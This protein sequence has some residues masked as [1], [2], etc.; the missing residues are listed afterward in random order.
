MIGCE[1]MSDRLFEHPA[2]QSA[3]A[4]VPPAKHCK[5]F[6]EVPGRD[7]LCFETRCTEDFVAEDA[8]V[9]AIDE[10]MERLDYSV[11]EQRYPGGGRPAWR[12]QLLAR[13]LLF[14][15][16]EGIRSAREISRLL[17]RDLHLM[18]LAHEQHI[19]HQRLSEFR[20]LFEAELAELFKQT[21]RLALEMGLTT[22]GLVAIDGSKIAANARRSTL[23]AEGLERAIQRV[24]AEAEAVDAAEDAELGE[25]RGDELPEELGKRHQRLEKLQQA[26]RALAASGQKRVSVTDPEAPVQKIGRDKR[27]GYNAQFAV[28]RE[29]G[30]VVAQDVTDAQQDNEQFGPMVERVMENTGFKP[31]AS[32]ADT[33]YESADNLRSAEELEVE[34]YLAQQQRPPSDRIEQDDFAYDAECDEF[35]C[36]AG[37]RLTYRGEHHRRGQRQRVYATRRADCRGCELRERCLS[38]S[39][40]HR[41]LY[42]A[43]HAQLRRQMKRRLETADGA[44]AMHCRGPTVEPAF[45]VLK[46]VLGLRQFLLRGL[47]GARVELTLAATALNLR[48]LARARQATGAAAC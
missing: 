11:F 48:K 36:P 39:L 30:V 8:P 44:Q 25:A 38:P 19:A 43:E 23:D 2:D 14:A 3:E 1:G 20:R 12:P 45:G 33:G 31:Q 18:W 17:E 47:A 34:A 41:R 4:K 27:P 13:I 9:R 24:L 40:E 10:I 15:Y 28:D 32:V 5:R 29:S 35:L 22:L 37:K 42:V 26:Q 46:S 7:Q 16:S 6:I 21:V